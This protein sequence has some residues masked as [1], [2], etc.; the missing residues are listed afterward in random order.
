MCVVGR[1]VCNY[2]QRTK[3]RLCCSRNLQELEDFEDEDAGGTREEAAGTQRRARTYYWASS[4]EYR[5]EMASMTVPEAP[6]SS[7]VEPSTEEAAAAIT[8]LK[9]EVKI[10]ELD[11]AV[12]AALRV[13]KWDTEKARLRMAD[14]AAFR[15][16]H[17]QLFENLHASEFLPQAELGMNSYLP[18]RNSRGELVV[19]LECEKLNNFVDKKFTH[20]DM[21]RFSVFLMMR[22]MQDPQTQINGVILLEN[23]ENYPMF[24][25]MRMRGAGLGNMK[26]SF[27]WLKASPM[28]LKGI[29]GYKEPFYIPA[30]MAMVKPFMSRKLRSRVALYGDKADDMLA[31][32]GLKPEEVPVA[33]GGTLENFDSAWYLRGEL[34]ASS[35]DS[36]SSETRQVTEE[37]AAAVVTS[38]H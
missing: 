31:A 33:Y 28:K 6:S 38:A 15:A 5:R 36:T 10:P 1:C 30:M 13:A 22:L 14:L 25:G 7:Y 8:A 3:Q 34:A 27:E 16:S 19:L 9:E 2:F 11:W 20:T 35:T 24:A 32:A 21:L 37:A 4:Y 17:P 23:L 29:Y 26:A 18:T 12:P